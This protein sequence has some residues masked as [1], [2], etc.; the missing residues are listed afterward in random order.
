MR[1]FAFLSCVVAASSA[2]AQGQ[3]KVWPD[4]S[5][6]ERSDA[7]K[8][9]CSLY[10]RRGRLER[11]PNSELAWEPYGAVPLARYVTDERAQKLARSYQREANVSGTASLLADVTWL[12]GAYTIL[13]ASKRSDDDR[14]QISPRGIRLIVAGVSLRAAA[15][16][17]WLHAQSQ[18]RRAIA[19]QNATLRE[20]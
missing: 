18:G 14:M 13:F 19:I 15:L 12:V 11:G 17:F 2:A 5:H 7:R 16:P 8:R 10:L 9:E 3:S 6:C 4:Q 1:T 20:E